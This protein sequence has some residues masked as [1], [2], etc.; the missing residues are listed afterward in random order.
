MFALCK[1]ILKKL[2][3]GSENRRRTGEEGRQL[4]PEAEE[5]ELTVCQH[6]QVFHRGRR[7]FLLIRDDCVQVLPRQTGHADCESWSLLGGGTV[8]NLNLDLTFHH[9]LDNALHP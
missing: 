2:N 5:E 8:G 7:R 9:I 4:R 3:L 6:L 1:A